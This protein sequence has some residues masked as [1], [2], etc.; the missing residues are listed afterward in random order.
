MLVAICYSPETVVIQEEGR[1]VLHVSPRF[2]PPWICS[3][4]GS[5]AEDFAVNEGLRGGYL[6]VGERGS[7]RTSPYK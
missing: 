4:P 3:V 5:T 1:L 6:T 7:I 2:S